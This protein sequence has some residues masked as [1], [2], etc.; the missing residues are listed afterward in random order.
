MFLVITVKEISVSK[1]SI[2]R[3]QTVATPDIHLKENLLNSVPHP[4]SQE[5]KLAALTFLR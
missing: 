1:R 4:N 2:G 3:S 5:V